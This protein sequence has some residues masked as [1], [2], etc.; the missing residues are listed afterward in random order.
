M[1]NTIISAGYFII[2]II[3][4]AF[5][6]MTPPLAALILKAFLMP[7]LMLLMILNL[8]TAGNR[9]NQMII[10]ALVFS[11]LGDIFLAVPEQSANLFIPGLVS[12]LLAH[13][14]YLVVFFRTPGENIILAKRSYFFLPVLLYGVLLVI[15]LF[16]SLG[17]MKLP[18][19]VYT[20]VIL[21]MVCSAVNRYGKVGRASWLLVLSG[22][23]LFLLS[24]SGIAINKFY[25]HFT[26]AQALIMS[27]YVIGQYLIVI[28]YIR[29]FSPLTFHFSTLR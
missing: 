13:V 28:G 7:C 21:T 29:Q 11:W 19:M 17:E 10:L 4:I 5:S 12:F 2:A 3:I 25:S 8:G 20:V 22:A 23:I 18:V 24:D 15:L 16:N 6:G 9:P 27:T 14:M 26:G 1:K